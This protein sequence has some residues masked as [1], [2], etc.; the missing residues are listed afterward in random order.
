M[1]IVKTL[2]KGKPM[3]IKLPYGSVI[4]V[5][6]FR[7]PVNIAWLFWKTSEAEWWEINDVWQLYVSFRTFDNQKPISVVILSENFP[8]YPILSLNLPFFRFV[9][10]LCILH[11]FN[12]HWTC[13][14][15]QLDSQFFARFLTSTSIYNCTLMG[16][17]RIRNASIKT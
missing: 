13:V 17:L 12:A 6:S 11:F 15:R 2:R 16:F 8:S 14:L 9:W 10:H 5:L 4:C 1:N 3:L 7:L